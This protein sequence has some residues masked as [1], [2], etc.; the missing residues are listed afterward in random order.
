MRKSGSVSL[1]SSIHTSPVVGEVGVTVPTKIR[2]PVSES[3]TV[4][5]DTFIVPAVPVSVPIP[6]KSM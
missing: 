4:I 2:F 6:E 1:D 3:V 5:G